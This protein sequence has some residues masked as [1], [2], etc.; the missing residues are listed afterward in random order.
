MS[1][2]VRPQTARARR[3]GAR[4]GLNLATCRTLRGHVPLDDLPL[5]QVTQCPQCELISISLQ[6][7]GMVVTPGGN[8]LAALDGIEL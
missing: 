2:A 5:T 7:H 1:S 6:V 4:R 3:K 8:R